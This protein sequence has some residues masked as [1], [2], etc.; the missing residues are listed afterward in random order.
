MVVCIP[1]SDDG[2]VDQRWGRARR[3]AIAQI[4]NRA[5]DGWTEFEV[6]W[7]RLHDAGGEGEHHARIASFLKE[8]KA[9]LVVA[10]HMGPPMAHMLDKMGIAVRLGASGNAREAVIRVAD[11]PPGV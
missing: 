1:V 7:D 11:I 2:S 9:E 4:S 3:V 10:G 6:A 8:H 5:L